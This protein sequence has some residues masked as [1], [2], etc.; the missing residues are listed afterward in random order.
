[1]AQSF[2]CAYLHITFST[3]E[4]L[5]LIPV[6]MQMRL[7]SYVGGILKNHGMRGLAIGGMD[8]HLH[9]LVSLSSE[10]SVAKVVNL[11]KSNCSKWMREACPDFGWQ[12]G[13][14]AFSVSASGLEAVKEY[15]DHQAE[16]HKQRDFKAEYLAL[17]EKHGIEF[18]PKRVFD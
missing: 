17:L 16:H 4:R 1:M 2:T 8:D 6:D 5:H 12:K 10:A 15:I 3:R 18:D 13:Y 9:V 14:A 11:I 7:W